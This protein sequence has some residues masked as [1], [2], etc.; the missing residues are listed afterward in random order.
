MDRYQYAGI[1]FKSVLA[2]CPEE[3]HV[4]FELQF[5]DIVLVNTVRFWGCGH[6]VT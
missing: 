3:V 6:W 5:E 1:P 4:V 2:F